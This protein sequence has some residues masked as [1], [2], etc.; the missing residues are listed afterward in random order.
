MSVI[1]LTKDNFTAE[2]LESKEPVL[3]DFW[4][5]WCTPCRMF[6]PV[7]DQIASEVRGKVKVGKVNVDEQPELAEKFEVRSIPMLVVMK[8]GKPVKTS[9][10]VQDKRDVLAML[11]V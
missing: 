1:E 9:T 3:I 11:S 7:V 6:S 10:G 5:P 8:D 2:V 4:A